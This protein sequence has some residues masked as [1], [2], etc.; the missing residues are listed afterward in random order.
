MFYIIY[1]MIAWIIQWTVISLVLII[2]I[3]YLYI[4]FKTTLTV[5]KIKDLVNRPH[6]QYKDIMETIQTP[7]PKNDNIRK[8][9]KNELKDYLL[10][11]K[12]DAFARALVVK[13]TTYALGRYLEF[14]D[15]KIVDDLT[16]RF[17]EQ[18]YRL[19]KLIQS[20]VASELF[21]TR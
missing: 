2:L 19:D 12:K 4:F 6:Q 9:M 18:G 3:H 20:I 16:A 10:R 5:P 11:E 21:L 14:T 7:Q 1:I 13:L 15:D 8:E 17:Q